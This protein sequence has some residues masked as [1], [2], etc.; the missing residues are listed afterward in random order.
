MIVVLNKEERKYLEALVSSHLS[1][2]KTNNT[3]DDR[4]RRINNLRRKLQWKKKK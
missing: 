4:V 1:Q 2:F 3:N